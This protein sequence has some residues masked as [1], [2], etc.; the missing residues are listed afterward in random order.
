MVINLPFDILAGRE[1]LLRSDHSGAYQG[2]LGDQNGRLLRGHIHGQEGEHAEVLH[3]GLNVSGLQREGRGFRGDGCGGQGLAAD[4]QEAWG[5]Q[6]KV[7][8]VLMVDKRRH[9][10]EAQILEHKIEVGERVLSGIDVTTDMDLGDQAA[11]GGAATEQGGAHL[12][13]S[14]SAVDEVQ[15]VP[16]AG[17]RCIGRG[18]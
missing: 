5:A 3:D 18:S 4:G 13:L 16:G 11:S 12:F 14:G 15:R 6:V 2:G 9:R 8:V 7:V 17:I 1:C 10:A